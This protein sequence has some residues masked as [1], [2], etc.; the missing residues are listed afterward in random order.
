MMID[1]DYGRCPSF[2]FFILLVFVSDGSWGSDVSS[3][4]LRFLCLAFALHL[5]NLLFN[6]HIMAASA[7]T[8]FLLNP[9]I[10]PHYYFCSLSFVSQIEGDS[11]RVMA[12]IDVRKM[13]TRSYYR[14]IVHI[15]NLFSIPCCRASLIYLGNTHDWS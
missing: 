7:L 9:I 13:H 14:C 10:S 12:S 4:S 6:D 8:Y 1:F 5:F 2:R 15:F 3:F 11:L